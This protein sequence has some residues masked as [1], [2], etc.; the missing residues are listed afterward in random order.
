VPYHLVEAPSELLRVGRWPNPFQWPPPPTPLSESGDDCLSR[1]DDPDGVFSTLYCATDALGAFIE[2][3]PYYRSDE[4]FLARLYAETNEDEPDQE[5]DYADG[6]IKPGFFDRV[7]GRARVHEGARFVD[8]DDPRTHAELT[9]HLRDV[10]DDHDLK[11]FDRGVM[12]AQRRSVTRIVA[13]FLHDQLAREVAGIR[14]ESRR[15]AARECWAIWDDAEGLF[16]SVETD[17]L[18]PAIPELQ[19]AAAL[20]DLRLPSI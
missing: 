15:Y 19:T 18:T 8:A 10:L 14:Y 12:M 7:L 11:E 1:W 6:E 13:G 20:L 3:L 2:T 9:K 4:D 17:P 16:H 5:L